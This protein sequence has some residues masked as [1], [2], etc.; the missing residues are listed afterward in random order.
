MNQSSRFN[1]KL[2][3]GAAMIAVV[4]L[5]AILAPVL[6]LQDPDQVHLASA[7]QGPSASH[8]LGQDE[9]GR[10]VLSRVIYGARLSLGVGV[11]VVLLSLSFGVLVGLSAGYFGGRVDELFIL[12]GDLFLA[13]PSILL[14]IA[15]A[16]WMPPSVFNVILILS[17]VGWVAYARVLRSQVMSLKESEFIQ[18]AFSLGMPSGRILWRHLLPNSLSPVLIQASLSLAGVIIAES[19]LSFLGLGLPEGL[20]SWGRMLDAGVAYLLMAPHL[21]MVPGLAI[22]WTVLGFNFLG[23]GLRDFYD[24]KL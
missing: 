15:L 9:E 4:S 10:D 8:W 7:L 17:V 21:S 22:L 3:L 11:S 12:V 13:F 1:F 16:A 14:I 18:A 19:V 23:D 5:L 20:P 6:P 24:V 2:K